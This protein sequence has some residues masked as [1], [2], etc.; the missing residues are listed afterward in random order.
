MTP[1]V[2]A[3]AVA[4]PST[5]SAHGQCC[6]IASLNTFGHF[7]GSVNV[8]TGEFAVPA[9]NCRGGCDC[10]H[11]AV[12][13][14]RAQHISAGIYVSDFAGVSATGHHLASNNHTCRDSGSDCDEDIVVVTPSGTEAPFC[15]RSGSD[16]VA[17]PDRQAELFLE[18]RPK[19]D[20]VPPDVFGWIAEPDFSSTMPVTTTPTATTRESS[21]S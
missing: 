3:I 10:F 11:A 13:A 21:S 14:A 6:R 8:F 7:L 4:R 2:H 1:P 16:V 20:V 18:H 12:A 9:G 15:Q 17:E 19:C 5:A